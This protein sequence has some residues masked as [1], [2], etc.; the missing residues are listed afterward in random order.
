[1]GRHARRIRRRGWS[2]Q[3]MRREAFIPGMVYNRPMNIWIEWFGTAASVIVAVS[4]TM[5]NIKRLRIL[6]LV[7]AL[8]F[9]AYGL[10][11]SSWPVFGLNAFIVLV[12]LYF[13]RA[14]AKEARKPETFDVLFVDP[15]SDDYARRFL[16]FHLNEILRFFPSFDNDPVTGSLRG[17]EACFILRGT[18]PVSFVAFRREGARGVAVILDYAIP[19]YRDMKSARFFFESAAS[20]IAPEGTVFTASA[21]TG[22]HASYLRKLGFKEFGRTGNESLFRKG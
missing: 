6:N 2:L 7:G 10:L 17:T 5:K 12:N 1:M 13:L 9:A 19:A 4:L 15:V 14:M 11:I 3:G 18:L 20:K 21:E 22:A 8:A 16:S